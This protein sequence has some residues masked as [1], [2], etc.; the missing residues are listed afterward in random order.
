MN[1]VELQSERLRLEPYTISDFY[2]V[3]SLLQD[4]R[5]M[6]FISPDGKPYTDEQ[7]IEWF[8]RQL[9]RYTTG[10]QTGLLKLMTHHSDE[11]IGHAGTL[12]HELDGKI[13]LEVGY[14]LAP[15]H[16]HMGYGREAAARLMQHAFEEGEKDIISLIHP[17]NVPSQCVAKSNGLRWDRD[18]EHGGMI[19]SVYVG[20]LERLCRHM[21]REEMTR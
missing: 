3:K 4:P 11:P 12:L 9:A 21:K 7:T 6:R 17:D 2:F 8:E 15:K 16:W 13:E 5:V 18:T 14:W 10:R 19:V 1:L 20:D